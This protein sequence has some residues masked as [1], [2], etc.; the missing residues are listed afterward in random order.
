MTAFRILSHAVSYV[1]LGHAYLAML[2]S[3]CVCSDWYDGAAGP[4]K[5]FSFAMNMPAEA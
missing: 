1:P 3:I 2:W 4:E 5:M